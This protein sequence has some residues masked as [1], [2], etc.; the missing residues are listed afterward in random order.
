MRQ[1]DRVLFVLDEPPAP[2][3]RSGWGLP[4]GADVVL[5]GGPADDAT[6]GLLAEL[7]PRATYRVRAG[8][9]RHADVAAWRDDSPDVRSAS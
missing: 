9:Q 4:S 1:A 3:L 7:D 6:S 8:A 5:L 2:E